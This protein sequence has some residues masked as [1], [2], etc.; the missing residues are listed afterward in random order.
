[1]IAAVLQTLAFQ[2]KPPADR[3]ERS[4]GIWG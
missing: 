1:V 3:S 2:R 4:A